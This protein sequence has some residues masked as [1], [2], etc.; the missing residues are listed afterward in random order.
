MG[1][2]K[3]PCRL[4]N[5]FFLGGDAVRPRDAGDAHLPR[6]DLR[7]GALGRARARAATRP[8]SA[9]QRAR[10]SATAPRSSRAT[11][12][13]RRAF[14]PATSQVG[15]V[16]VNVPIP[17]P[18][19]FHSFGGWKRLAVRRPSHARPGGR[20]VLHAHQDHHAALARRAAHGSAVHNADIGVATV[21]EVSTPDSATGAEREVQ[22]ST[23]RTK[24]AAMSS[25]ASVSLMRS[26][27][28]S[29]AA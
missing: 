29:R 19:A 8:L 25:T 21:S 23:S 7:A 10:V 28:H 16:G 22:R 27:S 26:H 18:M 11:A 24:R 9:D 6:R 14:L 17:V 13:R 15:M 4:E 2:A 3:R 12:T 1:A 20:A 5:G